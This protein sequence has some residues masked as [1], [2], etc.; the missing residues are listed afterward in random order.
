M[1]C[2]KLLA[3]PAHIGPHRGKA[4]HLDVIALGAAIF[5]NHDGIGTRRQ[6]AAGKDACGAAGLKRQGR[7]SG[8][9]TL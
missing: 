5:L 6:R 7:M 2:R 1:V 8:W 3:R 4:L 9:N